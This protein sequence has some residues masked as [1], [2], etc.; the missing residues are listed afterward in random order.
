MKLSKYIKIIA[1][2]L[3]CI[4]LLCACSGEG[5]SSSEASSLA[6]TEENEGQAKVGYIYNDVVSRD[7]MTYMFEKTRRDIQTALEI[8]TCYVDN[9]P[10]SQFENAVKALKNEGCN[11]IVSASN[12]FANSAYSYAKKDKDI[13]IM[14][15]GGSASL[16]NL[17]CFYP[18]IYQPAFI[19]GTAAA[20]NSSAHKIGVVC[21]DTMFGSYSVIN[22]FVLGVEQIYKI[23]ET[24]VKVAFANTNSETTAAVDDLVAQG[25]DVIFSYQSHDYAMYYCDSIGIK[26]IGFT[27]D[28]EYSAEK[29]GLMG[30]YL[31]W[32]TALTD[33]VRTCIYDNFTAEVFIGGINEAFVKITPYSANC[34]TETSTICDTLYEY[35]KKGNAKIFVG[36]LR[37]KDGLA[38]LGTGT[39][40]THD[41]IIDMDYLVYGVTYINNYITPIET[42][43]IPDYAVK[44]E[45]I[46]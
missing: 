13:Y 19:C 26:S 18:K 3:S 39:V 25:C 2:I 43:V 37:D 35:V 33:A 44:S 40:L 27:S 10:V 46:D 31:N 7:N 32:A 12:A 11:I 42:P 4:M 5:E 14:S 41:R 34:K 24:D 23:D 30:F 29:R 1:L 17:T 45:F 15:Y 22:A 16:S 6:G 38:R 9:I 28:V 21:D 36:E 20:W 8:E